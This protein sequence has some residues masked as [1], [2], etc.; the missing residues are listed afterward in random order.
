MD[1]D[2]GFEHSPLSGSSSRDSETVD[3]EIYRYAG[4]IPGNG[5]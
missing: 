1:E 5:S 3:V 2:H 4:R